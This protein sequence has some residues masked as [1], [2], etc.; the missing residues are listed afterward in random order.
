MKEFG[1][2]WKIKCQMC[3]ILGHNFEL[4]SISKIDVDEEITFCEYECKNCGLVS[5]E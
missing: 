3:K 5:F 1:I 4:K 2:V